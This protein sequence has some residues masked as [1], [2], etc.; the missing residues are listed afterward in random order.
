[1]TEANEAQGRNLPGETDKNRVQ[2]NAG[3]VQAVT[4]VKR[5]LPESS[6]VAKG[7]H[8]NAVAGWF[9]R[10]A[11]PPNIPAMKARRLKVSNHA[12]RSRSASA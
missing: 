6:S 1:M 3:P 4:L 5:A 12:R 7:Q 8:W 11:R 2:V 10:A 9:V